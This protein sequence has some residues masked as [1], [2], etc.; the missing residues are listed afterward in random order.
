MSRIPLYL[1][2]RSIQLLEINSLNGT[3]LSLEVPYAA[4]E[5]V[6]GTT[7][8]YI[9]KVSIDTTINDLQ[10]IDPYNSLLRCI[11]IEDI[12]VDGATQTLLNQISLT[13]TDQVLVT[14]Y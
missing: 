7:E 2:F 14:Q 3:G 13:M 1:V 6:D 12:R 10:N 5:N 11:S 4:D 8:S 9:A